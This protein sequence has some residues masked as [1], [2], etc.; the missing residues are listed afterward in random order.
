V[1]ERERERGRAEGHRPPRGDFDFRRD[2]S[3]SNGL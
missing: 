1:K 3:R 2:F